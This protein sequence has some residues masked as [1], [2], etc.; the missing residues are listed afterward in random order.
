MPYHPQSQGAVEAFNKTVQRYLMRALIQSELTQ[1][2]FQFDL[3]LQQFLAFYNGKKHSTT[4]MHPRETFRLQMPKD[5]AKIQEVIEKR[6]KRI[7]RVIITSS[8]KLGDKVIFEYAILLCVIF[9]FNSRKHN[10]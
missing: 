8:F 7:P 2:V 9:V 6:K 10:R 4:G 5:A 3:V 1:Q